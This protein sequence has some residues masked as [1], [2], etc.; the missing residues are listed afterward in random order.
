[1]VVVVVIPMMVMSPVMMVMMPPVVMMMMVVVVVMIPMM[2]VVVILHQFDLRTLNEARRI[3]L[4]EQFDGVLDRLEQVGVG[5]HGECGRRG[6]GH[7]LGCQARQER[8]RS[9]GAEKLRG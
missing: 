1:M 8:N 6:R 3:V 4:D 7:H 9:G 5:G 2:M